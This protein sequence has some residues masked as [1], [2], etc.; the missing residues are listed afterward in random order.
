MD[1]ILK[2]MEC[3][4]EKN[5]IKATYGTNDENGNL[6]LPADDEDKDDDWS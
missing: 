4:E 5:Q 2:D 1:Y 6:I 3:N